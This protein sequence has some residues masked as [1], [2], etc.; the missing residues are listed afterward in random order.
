M[1]Q[2]LWSLTADGGLV[3]ARAVVHRDGVEW[4]RLGV[5]SL[6]ALVGAGV[7][8]GAAGA[9]AQAMRGRDV[10]IV[11]AGELGRPGGDAPGP[12]RPLGHRAGP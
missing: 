9:E 11:G 8:Y 2:A 10:F 12:V 3:A 7:F 1:T 4:R 5:P 6:E